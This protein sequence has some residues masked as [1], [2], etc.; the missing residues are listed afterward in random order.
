MIGSRF[1]IARSK[2]TVA[3]CGSCIGCA[4]AL[5]AVWRRVLSDRARYYL[6]KR[7]GGSMAKRLKGLDQT[8]V[9]Q[10]VPRTIS[11]L[12]DFL[13]SFRHY[14]VPVIQAVIEARCGC[15]KHGSHWRRNVPSGR[16]CQANDAALVRFILPSRPAAGWGRCR[17]P[18]HSRTAALPGWTHMGKP[19]K[20]SIWRKPCWGPASICW[21]GA[22]RA[23]GSSEIWPE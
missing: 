13:L 11:V 16:T 18:W 14:V 5:S 3:R 1:C 12:P 23:G 7:K 17:R 6:R 15:G 4:W 22:R 8:L 19:C 2:S 21:P 10:V 20:R 9:L